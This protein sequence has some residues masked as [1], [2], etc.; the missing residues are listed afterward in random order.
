MNYHLTI[1]S[2]VQT[3]AIEKFVR[4]EGA[5]LALSDVVNYPLLLVL[6]PLQAFTGVPDQWLLR[7]MKV[8][9]LSSGLTLAAVVSVLILLVPFL[10]HP[11]SLLYTFFFF[12][13][14]LVI[15]LNAFISSSLL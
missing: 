2:P 5:R 6:L 8:L 3:A 7:P 4:A 13:H 1:Y 10:V 9:V 14:L 11:K 15:A 12:F